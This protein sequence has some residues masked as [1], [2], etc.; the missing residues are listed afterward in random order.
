M[1]TRVFGSESALTATGAGAEIAA[2]LSP[3]FQ[4]LSGR[5][6]PN[7]QEHVVKVELL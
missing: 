7:G 2:D 5:L 4:I 1:P 6:P 3:S